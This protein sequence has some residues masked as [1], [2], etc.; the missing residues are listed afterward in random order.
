MSNHLVQP[1]SSFHSPCVSHNCGVF[2]KISHR[3][4]WSCP[5]PSAG[6]HP[7]VSRSLWTPLLTSHYQW[8]PVV[9]MCA[10]VWLSSALH[11]SFALLSHSHLFSHF[12]SFDASLCVR[13]FPPPVVS[14]S[15][16]ISSLSHPQSNF[17]HFNILS[18]G[19]FHLERLLILSVDL[20]ISFLI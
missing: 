13:L 11:S 9:R 3:L 19:L 7:S 8:V 16:L 4:G 17:F 6:S 2:L 15:R 1:H 5:P 10:S 20:F 14:L 18:L 12:P